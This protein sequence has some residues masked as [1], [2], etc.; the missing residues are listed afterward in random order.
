MLVHSKEWRV[1]VLKAYEA[2]LTTSETA[3]HFKCSESSVR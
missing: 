2:G 1:D 3:L